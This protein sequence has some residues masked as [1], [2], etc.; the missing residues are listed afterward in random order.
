VLYVDTLDPRVVFDEGQLEVLTLLGNMAA[1]KITNARL[2]EHEQVR[3]RMAQELSS[4]TRIQR[5]LLPTVLPTVLGW[6]LD[7]HLKT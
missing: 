4:A 3:A 1:V 6:L 2:L 7:A 5:G